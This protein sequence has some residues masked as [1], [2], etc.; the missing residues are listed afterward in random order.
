MEFELIDEFK[1]DEKTKSDIAELLQMSFPEEDF[2]GRTYFKQLPHYR[3][4]LKENDKLIGQ[5]GLDY[6]VMSLNK[7]V[8]RVMGIIDLMIDKEFQGK[9]YGTKLL[10]EI[11]NITKNFSNNIDFLFLVADK[12][13]FY[14]SCG[15]K[16]TKQKVIWFQ[17]EEHINYGIGDD[18]FSDCLMYKQ[19][20]NIEWEED[21][22]LDMLGYWY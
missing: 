22:I 14:E 6:R 4:L 9:G 16:L 8:I 13:K 15:F 1:I 3:L 20:G 11:D 5:L 2:K 21:G 18:Y 19:I 17:T 7:K 10:K 12:H